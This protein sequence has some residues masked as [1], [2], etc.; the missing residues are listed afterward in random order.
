MG[1]LMGSGG[2]AVETGGPFVNAHSSVDP[3]AASIRV[4]GNELAM[5]WMTFR[6][7]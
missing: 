5:Q 4:P 1:R 2:R 7:V 3:T 6:D